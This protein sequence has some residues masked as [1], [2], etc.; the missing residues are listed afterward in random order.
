M[1]VS[2]MTLCILYKDIQQSN[3]LNVTL[4]IMT[5]YMLSAIMLSVIRLRAVAP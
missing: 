1:T 5:V 2:I 4:S 3:K